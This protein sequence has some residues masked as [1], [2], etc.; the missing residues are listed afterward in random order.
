LELTP[1]DP[2]QPTL[3]HADLGAGRGVD[4]HGEVGVVADEQHVAESSGQ[5]LGIEWPTRQSRLVPRLKAK[6]LAGEPRRV[7]GANL[8]TRQACVEL[9][10]ERGQ[11]QSRRAGLLLSL[12]GERS[13]RIRRPLRGLAVTEQPDHRRT[14]C[15]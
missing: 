7:V 6:R 9:Y 14:V 1:L 2:G 13:L 5:L 4:R 12:C 3:L 8:R 11:G 15:D 10:A